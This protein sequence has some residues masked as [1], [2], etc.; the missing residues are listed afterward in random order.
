MAP[1]GRDRGRARSRR[2]RRPDGRVGD[3]SFGPADG[4]YA[5]VF[6]GWTG[7]QALFV[8][9]V[10][11]WLETMLA[12]SIRYRKMLR[13]APAPGEASGDPHRTEPDIDD[14]LS[15]VPV[16]ARGDVV[17]RGVLRRARRDRLGDSL[18]AL[19]AASLRLAD[20]VAAGRDPRGRCALS[21]R[22]PGERHAR[23]RGE[24]SVAPPSTRPADAG[25]GDRLTDRRVRGLAVLRAHGAACPVDDGRAAADPARQAVAADRAT[26]SDRVEATRRARSAAGEP[27]SPVPRRGPVDRLPVAGVRALQRDA[28]ALASA[29]A[30]RPDA[31]RTAPSTSSSTRSSSGTGD[32]VLGPP[33]PALAAPRSPMPAASHTARRRYSSA[34]CSRSC[35]GCRRTPSTGGTPTSRAAR[36]ACP[37][38]PTSSSRPA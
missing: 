28:A 34:G 8:V 15:L 26:V 35:S 11:Y 24:R 20:R 7:V 18:P 36:A 1:Q 4:G 14:P 19:D 12:T 5:S 9:G 31:E 33:A 21:R 25:A 17:L 16:L 6:F 38:S 32:A 2:G 10:L 29:G 27:L 3:E 37:R 22:G 23:K 30:L 13:G